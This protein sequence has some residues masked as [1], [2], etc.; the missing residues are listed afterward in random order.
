MGIESLFTSQIEIFNKYSFS[1]L[2]N[3]L[4]GKTNLDWPFITAKYP[5][6]LFKSVPKYNDKYLLSK[7]HCSLLYME[8]NEAT[9]LFKFKYG[10]VEMIINLLN[11]EINWVPYFLQFGNVVN[12]HPEYYQKKLQIQIKDVKDGFNGTLVDDNKPISD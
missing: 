1:V 9:L 8:F 12:I 2:K 11:R 6:P 3:F 10:V 5:H 4:T 7:I